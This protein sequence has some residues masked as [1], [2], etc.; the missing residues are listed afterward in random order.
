M[1]DI[2]DDSSGDKFPAI[3]TGTKKSETAIVNMN[4][5][6]FIKIE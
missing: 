3:T 6:V 4:E 2:L 5:V 1:F